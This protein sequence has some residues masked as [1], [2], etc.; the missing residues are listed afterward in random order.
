MQM[1]LGKMIVTIRSIVKRKLKLILIIAP[2]DTFN[3]WIEE[4]TDEK[5]IQHGLTI[6]EGRKKKRQ[7]SLLDNSKYF[8]IN[9]EGCKVIPEITHMNWDAVILDESTSIKDPRTAFSKFMVRNF[10]SVPHRYILTGLP[11]PEDILNYF[12]QLQFLD[13]DIFGCKSYWQFRKKY[14]RKDGFDYILNKK[15][16]LFVKQKLAEHGFFLQRKEAGVGGEKIYETIFINQTPKL[17]KIFDTVKKEL[18]LEVDKREI[19]STSYKPVGF[20]YLCSLCGG[21]A[22]KELVYTR[23]LSHLLHLING[24]FKGQ[25]VVM[26]AV[27]LPELD[28]IHKRIA[29]SQLIC[30]KVNQKKRRML[31]RDFQAGKFNLLVAN[32]KCFKYGLNLS[33]AKVEIYY[34]RPASLEIRQQSEDRLVDTGDNE[35]VRVIDLLVKDSVDIEIYKSLMAKENYQQMW[36]RIV[37]RL[38]RSNY[39]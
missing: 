22:D 8:I 15:G 11:D 20:H 4:L 3:G 37:K 10:R 16:Y 26:W 1:R 9:P 12:Q 33:R 19:R 29:G 32:P 30:G 31:Q 34:S 6:L 5:E 7:K 28:L 24:R 21:F 35:D 2:F 13:R 17:N 38:Q 18:L 39:E 14:F 23:K 27:Y 25:A 36:K